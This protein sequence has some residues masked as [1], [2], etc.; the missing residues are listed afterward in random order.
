MLTVAAYETTARMDMARRGMSSFAGGLF[1]FMRFRTSP[2]F[3]LSAAGVDIA[4]IDLKY[5]L[6]VH[7]AGD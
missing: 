7:A 5:V 3:R 2:I 4:V 1:M 6:H